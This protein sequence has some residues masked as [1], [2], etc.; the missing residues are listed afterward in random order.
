MFCFADFK[1]L[2]DKVTHSFCG[3]MPAGVGEAHQYN[4][5]WHT[6]HWWAAGWRWGNSCQGLQGKI[7]FYSGNAAAAQIHYQWWA[8][9]PRTSRCQCVPTNEKSPLYPEL[10][11]QVGDGCPAPSMGLLEAGRLT[12]IP[13]GLEMRVAEQAGE[14]QDKKDSCSVKNRLSEFKD[15][16]VQKN[17][18]DSQMGGKRGKEKKEAL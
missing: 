2:K 5:P 1:A 12:G 13:F 4:W 9:L 3:E 7:A 8:L 18:R 17:N 11:S 6:S 10:P 14:K 16:S 15:Q